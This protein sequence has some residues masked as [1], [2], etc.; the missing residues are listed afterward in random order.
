MFANNVSAY[1]K[2]NDATNVGK[3]SSPNGN[4]LSDVF[5]TATITTATAP[6]N[7][8]ASLSLPDNSNNADFLST[9]D[10]NTPSNFPNGNSSYTLAAW[11]N[12]DGTNT[13]QNN[14]IIGWGSF[15]SNTGEQRDSNTLRTQNNNGTPNNLLNSW[16]VVD[17]SSNLPAGTS[18]L[19]QWHHVVATYDANTD[20]RKIYVDGQLLVADF[21]PGL[22]NAG[23]LNFG[24][25]RAAVGEYFSGNMADVLVTRSALTQA[26]IQQL[27]NSGLTF[28]S[29]SGATGALSPN[30]LVQIAS[31]A[32]LDLN[33]A[34]TPSG[35]LASV[36]GA[37]TVT[38]SMAGSA[39]LGVN[40]VGTASFSGV[41][42]DGA[43][44]VGVTKSGAGAQIFSGNNTYTGTTTVQGGRLILTSNSAQNA[45]LADGRGGGDVQGGRLVFDYNTAGVTDQVATIKGI[46]AAGFA[47]PTKFSSGKIRSSTAT[48]KIGLG[49]FDDTTAKQLSVAYAYYGDA[50]LDGTVNALDFNAVAT[51]F[52]KSGSV[53]SSGDFNY[54]GV[55]NT[56]DYTAMAANFNQ[57][58][59]VPAPALGALVP[60]PGT[61]L[62]TM[63]LPAAA[64]TRRRRGRA[65]LV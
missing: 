3:D 17:N 46:L 1:Y 13:A 16:Y 26:Q 24:I 11:V 25:G 31:G 65:D 59:P 18:L 37:G 7:H 51:G 22:N 39:I 21:L 38:S 62:L 33:G 20:I 15:G 41:I 44:T 60:E 54:D 27:I 61:I 43:G 4:D 58:L 14:G 10:G 30:S 32:I 50:N 29:F 9:V 5:G 12:V 57:T 36:G 23:S 35:G 19:N 8:T 49:Y 56:L 28:G 52:G 40:P 47:Q 63:V 6:A 48:S 53:W 64:L 2:F 45:V 34:S 42:E 55:V